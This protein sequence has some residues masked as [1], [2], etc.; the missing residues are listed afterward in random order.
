ME[1]IVLRLAA[2]VPPPLNGLMTP[3]R[4]AVA[5]EFL[6]FGAVGAVGFCCDTAV[7][8]ALRHAIGLYAAG[9]ASYVIAATVTWALNRIWTFRGRGA[10]PRHVQWA[11]FLAAN[12]LGFVL[13]RGTYAA[14]IAAAP[15]ARAWPV[16]AIIAGTAAGMFVNFFLSRRLVFR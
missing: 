2:L 13:N 8:Y 9:M 16:L 15:L 7:V 12:F 5:A 14:L 1:Q 4:L 6:R 11:R 3:S 10:G